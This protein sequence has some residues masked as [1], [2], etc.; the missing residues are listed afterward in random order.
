MK[1][2]IVHNPF[3]SVVLISG[4]WLTA[5]TVRA[6]TIYVDDDAPSGG[7]GSTWALAF[8]DLQ[9]A[10]AAA[11]ADTGIDVIAIAQGI[12]RPT[13]I[14]GDRSISFNPRGGLSLLGGFAGVLAP[15]P[16]ERD[17]QNYETILS[18]DLANNDG[19]NFVNRSD[20][21]FTLLN[22]VE[23]GL[24]IEG[25]SIRGAEDSSVRTTWEVNL[26][27]DCLFSGNRGMNGGALNGG[28]VIDRCRFFRNQATSWGGA[29]FGS[30]DLI[31]HSVFVE[32][33]ANL[34]GAI[35]SNGGESITESS[36]VGNNAVEG[37]AV[38]I[39]DTSQYPTP[40]VMGC[41][42]AGNFSAN[43]G[44]A[45]Y[46]VEAFVDF[47]TCAIV[48]NTANQGGAIYEFCDYGFTRVANC[49]ILENQAIEGG[50]VFSNC[51][52]YHFS[53]ISSLLWG[54]EDDQGTN[55]ESQISINTAALD[56][57]YSDVQGLTGQFDGTGN[58][59]SDPFFNPSATGQWSANAVFDLN[60]MQTTLTDT[61][62]NWTAGQWVGAFL[63]PNTSQGRQS[64]IVSNT[65]TQLKV[66]GDFAGLGA[67][68]TSYKILDI[69]LKSKSSC[70][71]AGDPYFAQDPFAL[72]DLDGQSRIRACRV[73]IGADELD[74][75]G[76][77]SPDMDSDGVSDYCDNCPN[78]FNPEQADLDSDDVGDACD[79]CPGD[80][81]F[82][83][84]TKLTPSNLGQNDQ[85]G[86]LVALSGN[87][88]VVANRL[89]GAFGAYVFVQSE[90]GWIRQ[91]TISG[92]GPVDIHRNT[93]IGG[94]PGDN[95]HGIN[96]GSAY[97]FVRI[98]ET[99][100]L[101]QKL[102][103]PDGAADDAFGNS[104]AIDGA[105]LIVGSE[106]DDNNNG[107]NSGSAY[108]FVRSGNTWS[109][110]QKITASDGAP[111]DHFGDSVAISGNT[112]IVSS[113]ESV[114]VFVR[115]GA[116]WTEQATLT[117]PDPKDQDEFGSSVGVDSNTV[118]VSASS[119]EGLHPGSGAVYVFVRDGI[120]WTLQAKLIV[121][122]SPWVRGF[123]SPVAISGNKLI[124]GSPRDDRA[125][126]DSG[127]AYVFIRSGTTW[128]QQAKLT[129]THAGESARFGHSVDITANFALVSAFRFG[130]SGINSGSAYAFEGNLI[131]MD[132]DGMPDACD[133][134]DLIA[135]EDQADCDV[136]G[137]GDACAIV[138]CIGDYRCRDCNANSIPD[139][140]EPLIE[141]SSLINVL[142]GIDIDPVMVCQTDF[143]SDGMVDGLDIQAYVSV[144]LIR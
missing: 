141:Q 44:G 100:T 125:G 99:W 28:T 11:N 17:V 122:D 56:L 139:G 121:V 119:S 59:A 72:T 7:D 79:V 129:A 43:R 116:L 111:Q 66:W 4:V 138:D 8:N 26:I 52:Y 49:T 67:T 61:T 117:S 63:N 110:Q 76:S 131:D 69:H 97:V 85:Y 13:V 83:H 98:G 130:I 48:G 86:A 128:S 55:E 2:A 20:N 96:S 22:M 34:G 92:F 101:L 109:L 24:L 80:Q 70:I 21:S 143:N 50:G 3:L 134:C 93:I 51:L 108:V 90:N 19:P 65:A 84:S 57:N 105:T 35:F 39:S 120:T 103:A 15:N 60:L 91:A 30:P 29:I 81:L 104:V 124:A 102:T 32:N 54:N 118:V 6:T 9:I 126:R 18:G 37:G 127:A 38:F 25:L 113:R 46:C 112:L 89:N 10:L 94:A 53:I 16:D 47:V 87:T 140:C 1:S 75:D 42:V 36:F 106:G 88:A 45:F 73:D 71:D 41:V 137:V 78:V 23:G 31:L 123:G 27:R 74:H 115:S 142:L 64:L 77:M 133:N 114:H 58:I 33:S 82:D 132:S 135:N 12:Y 62:A 5:S 40:K 68:G 144:I 14:G 95:G 107:T 136:D